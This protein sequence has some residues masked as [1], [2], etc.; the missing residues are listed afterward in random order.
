MFP[1]YLS[2]FGE[3]ILL[4]ACVVLFFKKS[5]FVRAN[6]MLGLTFLLMA[7]YGLFM[8][9]LN[10][11]QCF[12]SVGWLAYYFQY[13]LLVGMLIGPTLYVYVRL[14]IDPK[15]T[16]KQLH[17]WRHAM[18]VF[19]ALAY[20][21]YFSS[22]PVELRVQRLLADYYAFTWVEWCLTLLFYLQ[23]LGYFVSCIVLLRRLRISGYM[24]YSGGYK[25]QVKWLYIY[26]WVAFV[27]LLV[28]APISLC[29]KCDAV[30]TLLGMLV[31]YFLVGYYLFYSLINTGFINHIEQE[32]AKPVERI[33]HFDDELVLQFKQKLLDE[34]TDS[35]IYRDVN[36]SLADVASLIS[37]PKN[38]L[39]YL[40][41]YH[42]HKNFTQFINEYRIEEACRLLTEEGNELYTLEAIGEKCGFG[43]RW[44]FLR[45]FR[46][47]FG[48]M[49]SEY[50]KQ[51]SKK[52]VAKKL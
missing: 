2:F 32:M 25:T 4:I 1:E 38:Q 22:F 13:D 15:L 45:A 9:L 12:Q 16:I 6:R 23:L 44:S 29:L 41:N 20:I 27:V 48:M 5:A 28:T 47:H 51:L 34:V 17:L 50:Q 21:L 30:Y 40:L 7:I 31:V 8:L 26:F 10:R 35:K 43:S 14:L 36:C 24:V 52:Q 49:P 42:F 46:N 33:V 11:A 39:S 18:L 37:I 3:I 19:P